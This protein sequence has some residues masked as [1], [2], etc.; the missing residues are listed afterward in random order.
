L[1]SSPDLDGYHDFALGRD[2]VAKVQG[3]PQKPRT[4][5]ETGRPPRK[6][7][8]KPVRTVAWSIAVCS[9]SNAAAATSVPRETTRLSSRG[10]GSV[11]PR[12]FAPADDRNALATPSAGGAIQSQPAR[13]IGLVSPATVQRCTPLGNQSEGRLGRALQYSRAR[14]SILEQSENYTVSSSATN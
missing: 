7:P 5:Q 6:L 8:Q 10:G 1:A 13:S 9:V 2:R 4:R 12:L 11:C 3:A 14:K